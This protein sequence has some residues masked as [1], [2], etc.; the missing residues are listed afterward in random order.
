MTKTLDITPTPRILRTLGDI[1]FDVWQCLAE[2]TDN[3]LD[4]FR[5][6]ERAGRFLKDARL[7]IHWSSETTPMVD[8]E[9]IVEGNGPG[10]M[11]DHETNWNKKKQ[12]AEHWMSERKWAFEWLQE[13]W[14]GLWT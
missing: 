1:P 7:D 14:S 5:E 10:M 8:R 3:S 12:H 9:I 4:A 13:H 2:I 11:C 6:E